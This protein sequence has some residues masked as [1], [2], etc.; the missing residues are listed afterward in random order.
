MLDH[1]S[2]VPAITGDGF[3]VQEEGYRNLY[4][5]GQQW[6][7]SLNI[8]EV[9]G[10]LGIQASA[11]QTIRVS[12]GICAHMDRAGQPE[13]DDETSGSEEEKEPSLYQFSCQPGIFITNKYYS[14]P[15]FKSHPRIRMPVLHLYQFR[16]MNRP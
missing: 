5:P 3:Y 4:E 8:E 7:Q 11:V 15:V 14:P 13:H 10:G 1:V 2:A 12:E 6:Q 16:S 9:A